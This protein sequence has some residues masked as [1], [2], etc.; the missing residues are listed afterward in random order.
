MRY[1]LDLTKNN[2]VTALGIASLKGNIKLMQMLL[3]AGA[4]LNVTSNNGIGALY[5]AIK[6]GNNLCIQYLITRGAQIY[7]PDHARL[8]ASPIFQAIR[9]NNLKVLEI[10]SEA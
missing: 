9:N 6:G 5:L 7:Y 1:P 2:G 8:D 10:I 4:D 3:D